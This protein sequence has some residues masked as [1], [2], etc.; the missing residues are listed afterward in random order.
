MA[1]QKPTGPFIAWRCSLHR[2]ALVHTNNCN[3]IIIP[4]SS[5]LVLLRLL[6]NLYLYKVVKYSIKPYKRSF[7]YYNRVFGAL[8]KE[9][10]GSNV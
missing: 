6:Y 10:K 5:Y 8:L 2:Q 7:R 4:P 9:A 1:N 3:T